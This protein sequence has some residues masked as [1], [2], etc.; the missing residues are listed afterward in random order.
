MSAPSDASPPIRL[1]IGHLMLWTLGSAV[2]LGCFRAFDSGREYLPERVA[3]VQPFY[4]LGYSLTLGAQV[5][6]VLLFVLMRFSGKRG[7][8][9]Q[10]GHWLLLIEGISAILMLGGYGVFLLI[11]NRE[12]PGLY[13][14]FSLQIPNLA[15][16]TALYVLAFVKTAKQSP[17]RYAIAIA[18]LIHA[19]QLVLCVIT[20]LSEFVERSSSRWPGLGIW[21]LPRSLTAVVLGLAILVASLLDWRNHVQRDV[22][23]WTGLTA[24]VANQFLHLI[25]LAILT[26]A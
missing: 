17:W 5:G 13:V 12:F 11:D 1:S 26:S 14:Y 2:I 19:I 4:H 18:A 15:V 9:S 10:P 23:H 3:L 21:E 25:Y 7:F 8:P 6:S 20:I 16:C 24:L 22:L